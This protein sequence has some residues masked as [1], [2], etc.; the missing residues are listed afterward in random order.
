MNI[1]CDFLQSGICIIASDLAGIDIETADDA[2]REC[3]RSNVSMSRNYVTASLCKS[4]CR[5][6]G[7]IPTTPEIEL[8]N[9]LNVGILVRNGIGCHLHR[10]FSEIG[11]KDNDECGCL[12]LAVRMD[13]MGAKE[14]RINLDNL[15]DELLTKLQSTKNPAGVSKTI[16]LIIRYVGLPAKL[17]VKEVLKYFILKA[18]ESAERKESCEWERNGVMG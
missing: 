17:G 15:A 13:R 12:A 14:C 7:V 3:Q 16:S 6:K 1:S 11:V 2:C 4:R 5:A 8:R 9:L 10:I 18:I